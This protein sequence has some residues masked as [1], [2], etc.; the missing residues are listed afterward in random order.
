MTAPHQ[1][2]DPPVPPAAIL[3]RATH[4]ESVGASMKV[5][6]L[7]VMERAIK[8]FGRTPTQRVIIATDGALPLPTNLPRHV[9]IHRLDGEPGAAIAALQT[10]LGGAPVIGADV[11]R[12]RGGT[13]TGGVRVV[14]QATRRQAEDEIFGDLLRGDL[15]FIARHIN[16][17]ISF[18]ITRHV[19]CHLPITPNQVTL[20][21]AVIGLLGC[22]LIASGGYAA[23]IAGFLLAQFQSVLDGCDGELARVR[24][25]QSA[26]GE[27]LDT[28]V[29]DFLNLALVSSLGIGLWRA[30]QG[31][32]AAVGGG[33]A[34]G[35][36]LVYNVV[37]YRELILQG[38]G[39]ELIKINWSLT[40]GRNM[41]S[42]VSADSGGAA[43]GAA[44]FFL[45]LGRRD[46]FVFSW[47]VLAVLN[48]LPIALVW[49]LVAS[50]SCFVVAVAQLFARNPPVNQ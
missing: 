2:A 6:G 8:Q 26:I 20:G 13:L 39:G 32:P 30:G 11:V 25:Q 50:L 29:D 16:K 1:D 3:L 5:A 9:E 28:L 38:V 22:F 42:M 47:L 12:A 33:A 40:R 7:S 34:F 17:K 14:D 15:G 24:F 19:L 4:D 36:F 41:K 21:A 35:M 10:Q 27:W 37:S 48:L 23:M 49:A 18:R 44:R 43:G 46:T 31:W 45:T